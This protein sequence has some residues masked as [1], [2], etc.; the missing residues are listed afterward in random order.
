MDYLADFARFSLYPLACSQI[1]SVSNWSLRHR[2][3]GVNYEQSSHQTNWC[4]TITNLS[5]RTA[6]NGTV[7]DIGGYIRWAL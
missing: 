3:C 2:I 4:S 1:H 6:H 7:C 5:V